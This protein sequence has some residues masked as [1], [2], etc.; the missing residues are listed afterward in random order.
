MHSHVDPVFH[1]LCKEYATYFYSIGTS[2]MKYGA[3][4]WQ[5]IYFKSVGRKI[6]IFLGFGDISKWKY[7][8][9]IFFGKLPSPKLQQNKIYVYIV[10]CFL[11]IVT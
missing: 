3:D 10:T 1:K 9:S 7:F 8:S 11:L 2:K 4:I 5:D 6:R